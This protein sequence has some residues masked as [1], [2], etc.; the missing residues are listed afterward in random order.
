V[1]S[2]F[3]QRVLSLSKYTKSRFVYDLIET[4]LFVNDLKSKLFLP[5]TSEY[6]KFMEQKLITF[7]EIDLDFY[8]TPA[9][10]NTSWKEINCKNRNM[11][12]RYAFHGFHYLFCNDK[13]YHFSA[14]ECE[15]RGE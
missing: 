11:F 5:D 8:L 7:L 15:K 2:K 14:K 12:T 6:D 13:M 10:C 9:M 4:D 1:K 3:L